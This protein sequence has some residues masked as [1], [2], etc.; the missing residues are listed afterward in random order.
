MMTRCVTWMSLGS[1]I[2][3]FFH[4]LFF[5][6]LLLPIWVYSLLEK[7]GFGGYFLSLQHKN[8]QH[9]VVEVR[10]WVAAVW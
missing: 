10:G 4:S 8:A 3:H 9:R 1:S 2:F 7:Q 5:L 6:H